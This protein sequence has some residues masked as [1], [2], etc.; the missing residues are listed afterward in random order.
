M[1]CLM[2]YAACYGI[3]A[4]LFFLSYAACEIPSNLLLYRVGARRW[5]CD[6]TGNYQTGLVVLS[7]TMMAAAGVVVRLRSKARKPELET[8]LNVYS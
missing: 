7:V 5:L 3:G 2:G 8:N 1:L 6:R 4:G